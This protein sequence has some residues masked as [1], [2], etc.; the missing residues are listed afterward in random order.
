MVDYIKIVLPYTNISLRHL[1]VSDKKNP[2]SYKVE[3][4][5]LYE[6]WNSKENHFLRIRVIK[7][8]WII[9]EGSLR[10]WY[11][12]KTTMLDLTFI[13]L[14]KC[15]KMISQAL[16]IDFDVFL[17]GKVNKVEI[18]K[19]LRIKSNSNQILSS[20]IRHPNIKDTMSRNSSKSFEGIYFSLKFYDKLIEM[21]NKKIRFAKILQKQLTIIRYEIK[22]KNLNELGYKIGKFERIGDFLRSYDRL[23]TF[24]LE[25]YDKLYKADGNTFIDLL[26]AS[27]ENVKDLKKA[28]MFVGIKTTGIADS[29][30]LVDNLNTSRSHKSKL[31]KT[32]IMK[33]APQFNDVVTDFSGKIKE[34][35]LQEVEVFHKEI[36]KSTF[37]FDLSNIN[38]ISR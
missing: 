5:I 31:K 22:I 25:E 37:N 11:F 29:L 19:N 6:L 33:F 21:N 17:R 23:L 14:V 2:H 24:W 26:D 28:L 27:L 36:Q 13:S 12:G 18:G 38:L 15:L 20:L 7:P 30:K 16:E 32:F 9:I 10:K 34:T 35:Y 4:Y 8:K 1:T 3:S